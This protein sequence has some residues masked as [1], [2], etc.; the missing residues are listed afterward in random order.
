VISSAPVCSASTR[1]PFSVPI[2]D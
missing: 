1:W 2:P